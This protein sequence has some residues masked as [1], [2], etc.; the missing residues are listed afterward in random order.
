[1]LG[2]TRRQ[3]GYERSLYVGMTAWSCKSCIV[4]WSCTVIGG[5]LID[6]V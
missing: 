4:L 3:D 1:M 2:K 5:D 6:E